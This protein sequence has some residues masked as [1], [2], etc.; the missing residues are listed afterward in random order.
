MV[1]YTSGGVQCQDS[2]QIQI[3]PSWHQD[4]P[5]GGGLVAMA[6]DTEDLC[7]GSALTDFRFSD[8]TDFTC[9]LR[10]NPGLQKPNHTDRYEQFIY[11]TDPLAGQGIPN[12][13]IK[14][15]TAETP[16]RL[17]DAGGDPVPN[18]WTVDPATGATVPAYATSSGF[19]EG[20]VIKIPVDSATGTYTLNN[21]Y[22]ISFDGTGTTPGDQFQVTVRNWN[23]C[24]PWNG[25]QANPNA[26][27]ANTAVSK[28]IISAGPVAEAG[29]DG[30]IC[31]DG[32]F[33]TNGLVAD[34]TSSI[35]TTTGDGF[36]TNPEAPGN[37]VYNPGSNDIFAGFVDLV[38]HAF[39][40]ASDCPESTDTMR[41][42]IMRAPDV[43]AMV[44]GTGSDT[45]CNEMPLMI[46]VEGWPS[47][48]G[49]RYTWTVS[50]TPGIAG[51]YDGP[52]EGVPFDSDIVQ[53]LQN[54]TTELQMVAYTITGLIVDSEGVLVCSGS[55]YVKV[56]WVLPH[57]QL[58]T[59]GS[60]TICSGEEMIMHV[61]TSY[62]DF[63]KIRYTWTVY[64]PPEVIGAENGPET[65]EDWK[66]INAPINQTLINLSS[67]PRVVRYEFRGYLITGM[68]MICPPEQVSVAEVVVNPS[69]QV[70]QPDDQVVC[71][72]NLTVPV[73]FST[74]NTG[75]TTTYSW[76]NDSPVIGLPASGTG[77]IPSFVAVSSGAGPVTATITV[78]PAV[79]DGTYCPGIPEAFTITV[80]PEQFISVQPLDYFICQ[81]DDA[82]FY[83][84][85][86]G[87]F[88]TWQWEVNKGDVFIPLTDDPF[89]SGTATN[90]LTIS[91]TPTA[92]DNWI[93]RAKVTGICGSP[94]FTAPAIL[95]V[96]SNPV[97]DFSAIDPVE[98]NE[99]VPVVINAD[100]TGGTGVWT[101]HLWTGDVRFL[102]NTA[103]QAPTFISDVAG[104]FSL[105]YRVTDNNSC[106]GEDNLSVV[107]KVLT[108]DEIIPGNKVSVSL[109]PNPSESLIRLRIND[110]DNGDLRYQV[111]GINGNLFREKMIEEKEIEISLNELDPGIYFLRLIKKNKVIGTYKIVK[112]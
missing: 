95:K 79:T 19:F 104:T 12:L 20:P 99:N 56:I 32:I 6:P 2:R 69:G 83:A 38:L 87:T 67:S 74:M 34:A 47:E 102:N 68:G 65:L 106:I 64:A 37:A 28:I 73:N 51:A 92:F 36:F 72:G 39:K 23:I 107:V 44:M 7:V 110:Y 91:G 100:P 57:L 61:G 25:S 41:L 84:E 55:P 59:S 93:F 52:P 48:T 60:S 29:A 90:K 3:V 10:D 86:S 27:D 8:I 76:T 71:S 33:K 14:A 15:G 101:Q 103:I 5:E 85:A 80:Y 54:F 77:D 96:N 75:V 1:L 13:F 16:V 112:N 11:G 18:S 31:S 9:T 46:N 88:L 50:A 81:G 17:T 89:F 42:E 82:S 70:N 21:T 45:I 35:W 109:Y 94:L 62:P 58:F 53:F 108:G 30:S 98:V 63:Y 43:F 40:P 26:G 111:I 105:T 49:A 78:T 66:L 4:K 22:K 24:N 97:V